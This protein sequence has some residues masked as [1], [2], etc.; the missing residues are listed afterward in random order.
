M[1]Q[2]LAAVLG[3]SVGVIGT[4]GTAVLTYAATRSQVRDQQRGAHL[5]WL[6]DTRMRTYTDLF[7]TIEQLDTA[8]EVYE[9]RI[10]A[11][12][13]KQTISAADLDSITALKQAAHAAYSR[14]NHQGVQVSV[15]GPEW[16]TE[17]FADFLEPTEGLLAK[18]DSLVPQ[19]GSGPVHADYNELDALT[20]V[21][22]ERFNDLHHDAR[23]VFEKPN[24]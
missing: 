16:L 8:L 21:T 24:P 12:R 9:A 3:A 22:V 4:L 15:A 14:V 18:L 17:K 2:G 7:T 19:E 6:R 5:A 23:S 13:R 20:S 11:V 10:K 1:D